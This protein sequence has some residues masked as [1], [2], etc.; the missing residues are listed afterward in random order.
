[1][2][3]GYTQDEVGELL[4]VPRGT[5]ASWL[6]RGRARLRAVLEERD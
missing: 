1:V 5:V 6:S 4:G 2:L 3:D